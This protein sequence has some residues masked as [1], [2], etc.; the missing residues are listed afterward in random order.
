MQYKHVPAPLIGFD[1]RPSRSELLQLA[2]IVIRIQGLLVSRSYFA[3]RLVIA[4]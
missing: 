4:D 2:L 1:S 3:R